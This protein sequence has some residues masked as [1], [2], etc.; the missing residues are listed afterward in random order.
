MEYIIEYLRRNISLAWKGVFFHLRQYVSFFI[1]MLVI[2]T[3]YGIVT[4]SN[5]RNNK[6]EYGIISEVY[7]YDLMFIDLN[8]QQRLTLVNDTMTVFGDEHIFDLVRETP[9]AEEGSYDRR[10]DIYIKFVGDKDSALAEFQSRYYDELS[11]LSKEGF[12]VSASPMMSY[13]SYRIQSTLYYL[14]FAAILT[15][16]SVYFMMNLYSIRLNH[17]SFTYGIYMTFGADFKKLFSTAAWEML[18]INFITFI[19][20]CIIAALIDLIIYSAGGSGFTFHF[21]GIFKVLLLS[22]IITLTS[23]TLPMLRFSRQ[24]T[25]R[26]LLAEDN[27]NLVVSPRKSFD[28]HKKKYPLVYEFAGLWRFRRY[29]VKQTAAAVVFTAIFICGAFLSYEKAY[30]VSLDMPQFMFNFGSNNSYTST[31]YKELS[32]IEGITGIEKNFS[33]RADEI[34]S[35]VLFSK[36][37]VKTSEVIYDEAHPDMAATN[38]VLYHPGDE[39]TVGILGK[40]SFEGD[41]SGILSSDRNIIISDSIKNTYGFDF[42]PGDKVLIAKN[43]GKIKEIDGMFTGLELLREQFRFYRFGYEEYTICAVLNDDVTIT[44]MNIYMSDKAFY[45][46][47]G[48]E[49]SYKSASLYIDKNTDVETTRAIYDSLREYAGYY[50]G[51]TVRNLEQSMD[52]KVESSKQKPGTYAAVASLVVIGTPLIWLFSQILYY[53]KRENE[54]DILQAFGSTEGEIK[55]I[56]VIDA[57]FSAVLGILFCVIMDWLALKG[58]YYLTNVVLPMF[59]RETI[60]YPFVIPVWALAAAL[61]LTLVSAVASSMVPYILY[62]KSKEVKQEPS[63]IL[64]ET[65]SV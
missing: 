63:D 34:K 14:A 45:D 57:V 24:E 7:D 9:R 21:F 30:S 53:K 13:E 23:V 31:E 40:G 33:C 44:G 5:D 10:Y 27:S 1:A 64:A 20:S 61:L 35:H 38:F 19:P 56:Y 16:V 54:F 4:F 47:T 17:Y 6:L 26:A 36:P 29:Y 37:N 58:I 49:V 8:E 65:E 3:M 42:N 43:T 59:Y 60:R 12:R 50:N 28:F 41:L 46:L 15:A 39:E 25:M 22:L 48:M 18:I 11:S 32:E 52:Y 62:L 55:R 51:A 2:Q